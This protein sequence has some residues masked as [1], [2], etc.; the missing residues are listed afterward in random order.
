LTSAADGVDFNFYGDGPLR[1]SWTAANSD[2]AFLV[3]DRNG[4]GTIDNGSELFGNLTPQP[5][6]PAGVKRNGFLALAEYDKP[7]NGGN[8]DGVIDDKDIIFTSLRLWQDTNHN[9][10]SEPGELHTL[11]ELG[12]RKLDL[13][14]KESKRTD[15]FGNKFEYRAKVKDSQDAQLGRWAWD[16]F[17]TT[18]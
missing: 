15:E 16:V 7:E 11:P 2:D 14:Y 17:L 12:L 4:N 10:I 8:G 9:G 6:P 5:A 3:L 18:Q 13:D 1:L